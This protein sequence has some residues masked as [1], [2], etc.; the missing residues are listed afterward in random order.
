MNS[1]RQLAELALKKYGISVMD[2]S[3]SQDMWNTTYCVTDTTG[4]KYNLRLSGAALQDC[5]PIRDEMIFIDF[6]AKRNEIRVPQPIRNLEGEFVT[7]VRIGEED[8]PNDENLTSRICCLFHWIEGEVVRDR[9]TDSVMHKM[10]VA[11]ALLHNAAREFRFPTTDDQFRKGYTYDESVISQ[12]RDWVLERE[13]DI[14]RERVALLNK[15]IDCLLD[16]VSP[17]PKNR[18]TYGFLHADLNPNNVIVTD[19][20]LDSESIAVIDFEQLGWGH[21]SFDLATTMVELQ[22][23]GADFDRY[24]SNLKAGYRTV[25]ELPFQHEDELEPFVMM[26][27]MNFLDW[28]Y[29][30]PNPLVRAKYEARFHEVHELIR[31]WLN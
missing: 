27:H 12:H 5:A 8:G 31:E 10:G 11:T 23:Y 13:A 4:R 3:L 25:A 1:N 20:G 26:V 30:T 28:L 19:A 24:W 14:G 15:A 6:I 16:Q 29:N 7:L 2:L 17:L 22:E 9:L 21:Y 18:Q